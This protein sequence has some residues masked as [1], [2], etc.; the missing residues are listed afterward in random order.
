MS[1]CV[2]DRALRP[3]YASYTSAETRSPETQPSDYATCACAA[4]RAAGGI[5]EI[6][7]SAGWWPSGA[8]YVRARC[9][10]SMLVLRYALGRSAASEQAM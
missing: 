4:A 9:L 1:R 10:Q 6:D 2:F 7:M 3:C 5:S 8:I